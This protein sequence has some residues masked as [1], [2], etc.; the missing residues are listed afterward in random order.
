MSRSIAKQLE[1]AVHSCFT[2]RHSKRADKF[3]SEIDTSWKIYSLTYR[4]D[5]L[6]L[7]KDFGKFMKSNYPKT[8]KAYN[9]LPINID[10]YL[11]TK[12]STCT[13]KTLEK[14]ITRLG[15]LENCCKH[16]YS[17]SDFKW[18]VK[19]IIKPTST[20]NADFKKDTPIPI[21]VS[22]LAIE[23]LSERRSEVYRAVILS[24]YCGMRAEETTCMKAENIHFTG[25]EFGYGWVKILKGPAGG[26]KG[27]RP[28][29]IPIINEEAK[30][31]LKKAIDGKKANEYVAE[32]MFGGKM[33][34][35]NVQGTLRNWM[36]VQYGKKYKGNRCHGL[37]KTWSQMYYD[38]VRNSG[39]VKKDAIS[40]TND[41]IGH[42]K[43]RGA[44]G[45]DAYVARMW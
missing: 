27:G 2:P 45:I 34:P 1:H 4:R 30:L 43:K 19:S 8:S 36:D 37:R 35:D 22:K 44:Q 39:C 6:D 12:A 20:K 5:M 25:G 10:A 33:T 14:I 26:A 3:N 9:I 11:K 18:S 24:T 42:G 23:K 21:E 28:R 13:D 29:T 15:K 38:I 32:S 41:V 40:K 16:T 31:M 17:N 7:A